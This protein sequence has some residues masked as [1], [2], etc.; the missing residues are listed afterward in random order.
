MEILIVLFKI[1]GA[2][3]LCALLFAGMRHQ[4]M[5][6]ETCFKI[7]KRLAITYYSA[8]LCWSLFLVL[9]YLILGV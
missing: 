8:A 9:S 5:H 6:W 2:G 1:I 7:Y 4:A 3:I